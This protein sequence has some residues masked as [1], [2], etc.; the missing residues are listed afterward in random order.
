MS[1]A[2]FETKGYLGSICCVLDLSPV[3]FEHVQPEP[4]K[5]M[6]PVRDGEVVVSGVDVGAHF[7]DLAVEL[8]VLFEPNILCNERRETWSACALQ[9]I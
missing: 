1:F 4:Q 8:I 9:P 7:D 2:L 5:R 3:F 6:R